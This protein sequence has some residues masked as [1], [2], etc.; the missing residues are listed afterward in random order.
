MT[1]SQWHGGQF[2]ARDADAGGTIAIEPGS[3]VM[4]VGPVQQQSRSVAF[5]P[6]ALHTR[7]GATASLDEITFHTTAS[8]SVLSDLLA[9]LG[10]ASLGTVVAG[11]TPDSWTGTRRGFLAAGAAAAGLV[12][13]GDRARAATDEDTTYTVADIGVLDNPEGLEIDIMSA[14]DSAL[15]ADHTFGVTVGDDYRG[16]LVP[17]SQEPLVVP[18]GETGVVTVET[19]A[20]IPAWTTLLGDLDDPEYHWSGSL[21]TAPDETTDTTLTLT[22]DPMIVDRV[23]AAGGDDTVL[24]VAGASIPHRDERTGTERGTWAIETVDSD[25]ALQYRL[26][27]SPPHGTSWRVDVHVSTVTEVRDDVRRARST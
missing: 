25:P 26:G 5:G 10:L 12:A 16:E 6:L 20:S 17:G 14:I 7:S 22:T 4:V 1:I 8:D 19:E 15:P 2:P 9:T 11:T 23:A 13:A 27:S 18:P 21:E 3:D 24:T